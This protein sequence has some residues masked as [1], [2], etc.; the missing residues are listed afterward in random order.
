[1][2]KNIYCLQ[3]ND[4]LKIRLSKQKISV[5]SPF[6]GKY[7]N[8]IYFK[9]PSN[10][11]VYNGKVLRKLPLDIDNVI[12]YNAAI[13]RTKYDF[14]FHDENII[15]KRNVNK[16]ITGEKKTNIIINNINFII[17]RNEDEEC[18][19]SIDLY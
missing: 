1:M 5:C 7:S 4:I 11:Y 17:N 3:E 12:I 15:V 14:T 10:I 13:K 18:G 8:L 2:T 16:Y 9:T 19:I 6:N